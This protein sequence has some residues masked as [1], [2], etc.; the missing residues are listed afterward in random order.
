MLRIS[1]PC[2]IAQRSPEENLFR[3]INQIPDTACRACAP[4]CAKA[5]SSVTDKN[6]RILLSSRLYCRLRSYTESYL[7]NCKTVC[8]ARGL[9]HRLG[10]SPDPE[11]LHLMYLYVAIILLHTALVKHCFLILC[12]KSYHSQPDPQHRDGLCRKML[13]RPVSGDCQKFP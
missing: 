9:Y 8:L 11:E 4:S 13:L 10:L 5:L 3:A 7:P 1:Q 2:R 12:S 6:R